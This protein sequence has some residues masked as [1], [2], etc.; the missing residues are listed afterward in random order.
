MTENDK[1]L[2][3]GLNP[4]D[5]NT[6]ALIDAIEARP[7]P[8]IKRPLGRKTYAYEEQPGTINGYTVEEQLVYEDLLEKD[9]WRS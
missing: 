4:E 6:R 3:I 2:L 7:I 5:P 8:A 1:R 9:A